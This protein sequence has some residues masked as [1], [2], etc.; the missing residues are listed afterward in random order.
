[1]PII[2]AVEEKNQREGS[3]GGKNDCADSAVWFYIYK[4]FREG[5]S[6]ETI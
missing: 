1:M 5:L 2:T 3:A 6:E 4:M